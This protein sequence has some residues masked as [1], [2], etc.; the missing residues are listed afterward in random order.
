ELDPDRQA[1]LQ[2]RQQVRRLGD[3]ERAGGDEQ[4]VGGLDRTVLGRHRGA[5]DQRQQVALH[6][7]T[8]DVAAG[9]AVAHA[10]LVDLVEK[11]DAVVLDHIDRFL[12]QLVAVE[13][14]VGFL[15]DQKLVGALDGDAAGLGPAAELAEDVAN[16]D[17]AH[18]RAGHAGDLEHGHAAGGLRLDLDFLVVEFAG[19]ELPAEGIAGRGAGVGADQGIKHAVLGGEL[20][21]GLHVLALAFAG[22]RDRYLDEIANDLLDVT[23]DIADLGEFGGF[24]LDEGCAGEFGQPP[25]DLGLADPGRADHQDIL[26]Q[27]LLAKRAGELQPPPA[28]AQ[29][30]RDGALGVGLADDEAVEFGD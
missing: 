25:G 8:R 11:H 2:F 15:V 13:Q 12:H 17:R 9:A 21:A 20:R 26:R 4:D 6:A 5:L 24:D 10:D 23:A 22:L 16:R 19:A 14:L 30:D 1:A 18:L 7:L 28:I 27:H 3:M 29:R